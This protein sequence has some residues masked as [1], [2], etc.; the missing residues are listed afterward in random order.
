MEKTEYRAVI[1][2]LNFKELTLMQIHADMVSTLGN[3]APSFA[4]VKRWAAEFKR[5]R[6]SIEDEPRSGRPSTAS[7]QEYINPVHQMVM[8][9]KQLT[10]HSIAAAIGISH[11]RVKNILTKEL[12]MPKVSA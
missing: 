3:S 4:T 7:T 10:I 2:Y 5:G 1:K 12:G 8:D 11:E 6:K 9:D